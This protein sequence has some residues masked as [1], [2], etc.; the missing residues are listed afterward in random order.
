MYE[1]VYSSKAKKNTD[2]SDILDIMETAEHT[3]KAL[4]ITGCLVYHNT[5]F[6]Q[7]L[8]GEKNDVLELYSK[9][10][11]DNRH[12]DVMTLNEGDI[13]KRSFESW[14][15]AYHNLNEQEV[16]PQDT[17]LFE[18]NLFMLSEVVDR[19]TSASYLFWLNVRKQ[20]MGWMA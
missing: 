13:E 16:S 18:Q 10:S 9:I 3:N 14:S 2:Q 15:M 8:E 20:V 19:S 6:V 7:I 17:H 4:N 12:K 1:L 11:Q 5:S